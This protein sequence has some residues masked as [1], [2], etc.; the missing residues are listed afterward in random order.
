MIDMS[1]GCMA[2]YYD[3]DHSIRSGG[4]PTDDE[5]RDEMGRPA[6]PYMDEGAMWLDSFDRPQVDDYDRGPTWL[7]ASEVQSFLAQTEDWRN[8]NNDTIPLSEIDARYAGNI[9]R[10]LERKAPDLMELVDSYIFYVEAETETIGD[11]RPLVGRVDP[12]QWMRDH[13]LYQAIK[14][15]ADEEDGW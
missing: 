11:H 5:L 2:D 14:R 8:I 10:F 13:K 7:K 1:D 12:V 9:V 15:I 3:P 4:Y 6:P